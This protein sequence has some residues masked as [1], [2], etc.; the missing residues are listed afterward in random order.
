M[1]VDEQPYLVTRLT[2]GM[3]Y[4]PD[5]DKEAVQS[6]LRARGAMAQ[7]DG[8]RVLVECEAL[9]FRHY[10][11][12]PER[13]TDW[14]GRQ[15]QFILEVG[16]NR[17]EAYRCVE[18][19]KSRSLS[20]RQQVELQLL[21]I[22]LLALQ[23]EYRAANEYAQVPAERDDLPPLPGLRARVMPEALLQQGDG[24]DMPFPRVSWGPFID[25][26]EQVPPASHRFVLLEALRRS[27]SSGGK[28]DTKCKIS[29]GV[30][31]DIGRLSR[32]RG[33]ARQSSRHP[34]PPGCLCLHQG[35]DIRVVPIEDHLASR[36]AAVN[37]FLSHTGM[38]AV[39]TGPDLTLAQ[40]CMEENRV[41]RVFGVQPVLTMLLDD[42]PQRKTRRVSMHP[43]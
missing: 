38:G 23:G 21:E 25:A 34:L 3:A 35:T 11:R 29:G 30:T 6:E 41:S 16:G 9:V 33:V 14:L 42:V 8:Q 40:A 24:R 4:L 12:L 19:L 20:A 7:L 17:T 13:G 31:V 28:S 5:E 10:L 43:L 36:N 2:P 37:Q 39:P 32:C 26:L 22:Q 1:V 15:V 18:V 27:W